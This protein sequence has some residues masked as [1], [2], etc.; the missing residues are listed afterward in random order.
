MTEQKHTD[1]ERTWYTDEIRPVRATVLGVEPNEV[2][3]NGDYFQ[4]GD[5]I[6]FAN[7]GQRGV[8]VAPPSVVCDAV[9]DEA[10]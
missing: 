8:V 4:E 3:V 10:G 7:L 5:V 1:G 6:M 2:T 9:C